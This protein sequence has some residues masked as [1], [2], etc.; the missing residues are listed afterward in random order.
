YVQPLGD[1]AKVNTNQKDVQDATE[2]AVERFNTKSKAKKYFRLVDVTSA[3]M[4]VTNMINYKI[5]AVLGK[6]KCPKSET[7]TDL[8]SCDM[9][10]K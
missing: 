6:T 4:K 9:A 7:A 1:W 2:K 3:R 8:D 10:Q 5:D